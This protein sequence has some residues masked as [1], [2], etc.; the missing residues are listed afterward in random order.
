V[1]ETLSNEGTDPYEVL[2]IDNDSSADAIRRAYYRRVREHPP[3]K[4]PEGFKTVRAAYDLLSD[5]TSRSNYDALS[6]HGEEIGRLFEAARTHMEDEEWQQ[7]IGMLKRLLVLNSGL[8]IGRLYLALCYYRS[9]EW[10][11]AEATIDGLIRRDDSLATYW[12]TLG[13]ILGAKSSALSGRESE[14]AARK[15]TRALAR[16]VELDPYSSSA[17]AELAG[18]ADECGDYAETVGWLEKAVQADGKV[19]LQD[20]DL[21][22]SICTTQVRYDETDALK[23][24]VRRIQDL[25]EEADDDARTYVAWRFARATHELVKLEAWTDAGVFAQACRE[26]DPGDEE[27]TGFVK[28]VEAIS[29]AVEEFST[30]TN[31]SS[32]VP[33]LRGVGQL[34]LMSELDMEAPDGDADATYGRLLTALDTYSAQSILASLR[35][36]R[37]NYPATYD[38]RSE[39]YGQFEQAASEASQSTVAQTAASTVVSATSSLVGCIGKGI[40]LLFLLGILGAILESC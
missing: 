29:G 37:S 24:T 16:S 28:A 36:L 5:A 3:E 2:G 13:R 12:L 10:D 1:G 27:L 25:V 20:F 18:K 14:D 31:D 22:F 33:P 8:D 35:H 15:S 39:L 38:L 21:L 40:G 11:D 32:I 6:A 7:A 4:D 34:A 23:I 26:L 9:E 17:Y 30:V 19:D